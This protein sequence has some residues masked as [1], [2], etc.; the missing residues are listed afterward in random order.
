MDRPPLHRIAS[1]T[2]VGLIPG[3]VASIIVMQ[4]HGSR[5][6]DFDAGATAWWTLVYA[7]TAGASFALRGRRAPACAAALLASGLALHVLCYAAHM[8]I[9]TLLSTGD[10]ERS[11][12][13]VVSNVSRV[14]DPGH[15][16]SWLDT[17]PIFLVVSALATPGRRWLLALAVPAGV[18]AGAAAYVIHDLRTTSFL[19][20]YLLAGA[21]AAPVVAVTEL[22]EE[23]LA[24]ALDRQ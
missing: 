24:R 14:L 20:G 15:W 16:R 21:L 13:T 19:V 23:R 2:A 8:W 22:A 6:A 5:D 11:A 4:L 18:A 17:L 9:M 12:L 3:L 1:R 7:G 10:H